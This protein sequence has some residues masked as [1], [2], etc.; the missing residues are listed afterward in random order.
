MGFPSISNDQIGSHW[1]GAMAVSC[2]LE[3]FNQSHFTT[4]SGR[5]RPLVVPLIRMCFSVDL[6]AS[7]LLSLP[8]QLKLPSQVW[9]LTPDLRRRNFLTTLA[10]DSTKVGNGLLA[11]CRNAGKGLWCIVGPFDRNR[12]ERAA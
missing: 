4:E 2:S 8:C 12:G 10:V 3:P 6:S 11:P 1:L 5:K 7:L 9:E